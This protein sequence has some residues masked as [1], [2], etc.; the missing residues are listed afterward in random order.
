MCGANLAP[1]VEM[2]KFVGED[3]Y[4]IGNFLY[5]KRRLEITTRRKNWKKRKEI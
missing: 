4:K 5:R 3:Q 1:V 2:A